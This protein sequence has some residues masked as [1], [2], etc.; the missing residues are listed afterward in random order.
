[1]LTICPVNEHAAVRAT[2]SI[3]LKRSRKRGVAIVGKARPVMPDTQLATKIPAMS[4]ML[5]TVR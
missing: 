4:Q 5:L 3:G 2:V 1:M